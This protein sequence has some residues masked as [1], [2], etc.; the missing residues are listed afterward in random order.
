MAPGAVVQ[1]AMRHTSPET[2][3]HY[4]LGMADQVRNAMDK[5]NK[6]LYGKRAALHLRD[7][8]PPKLE[9]VKIAVCN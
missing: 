9:E 6:R 3:R 8:Q 5:T 2:K 4:Q 7:S 1:R